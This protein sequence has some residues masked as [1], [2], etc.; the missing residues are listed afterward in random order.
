VSKQFDLVVF[1]WDGTLM[2]S[3]QRIVN[4]FRAAAADAGQ[5]P[6]EPA[7]VRDIIGLGLRESLQALLPDADEPVLDRVLERY[8]AHYME[9]DPTPAPLF[10]GVTE[11]LERLANSGFR[12]A[13]ATGKS[14]RGLDR[15]LAETGLRARFEATRCADEAAPKPDPRMLHDLVAAAGVDIAR[16][17]MVGDTTH[18]L[19]MARRAGV[20]SVA[21]SYGAHEAPRLQAM[22]PLA[23]VTS[24][25]A[26]VEWL[27]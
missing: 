18:D 9:L 21:V 2:D 4:C 10:H 15:A 27:E 23:C 22:S 14:R 3:A 26:V 8:R 17:V 16:T 5:P 7:A 12:L 19:E 25:E 20:A 11:G 13:V 1:D 6:P 24:F